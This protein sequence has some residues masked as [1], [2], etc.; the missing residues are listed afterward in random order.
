VFSRIDELAERHGV[1]K[2]RNT[3]DNWMGVS[4]VP[5]ARLD[6]AQTAM[7]IALDVRHFVECYRT[8]DERSL[9]VRIGLNSGPLVAGVIGK[10]KFGYDIWSDTVN[11]ASRME[12]QGVAG[13]VHVSEATYALMKDEFVFEDRGAIN[14]RGRGPLNTYFVL[15][16]R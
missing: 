2:I 8:P 15:A 14:V 1:E 16:A 13:R 9:A 4:G 12:S 11:T 7:R 10:H 5:C 6:H 3:G